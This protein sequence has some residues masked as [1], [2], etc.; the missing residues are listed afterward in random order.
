MRSEVM[1]GNCINM[2]YICLYNI[3]NYL[4]LFNIR[5]IGL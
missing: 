4:T 2:R 1:L 3:R 5:N